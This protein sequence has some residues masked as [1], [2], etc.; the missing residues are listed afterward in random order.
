MEL[1]HIFF[2][3]KDTSA[4]ERL[5][6]SLGLTE[7]YR[8]KHPGQGTAN[9]CYCF[10]NAFLELLYVTDEAEVKT[11]CI[12]RTGL[13][14]RSEWRSLGTSPLGI[15]W[16][17]RPDEEEEGFETWSFNPP[18]MPSGIGIEV[19][20]DGDDFN[21]P[22]MFR[23]PGRT[24]TI[25]WPLDRRGNLQYAAG[26]KKISKVI[27]RHPNHF[28]PRDCLSHLANRLPIELRESE[29][30]TWNLSI[31]IETMDEQHRTLRVL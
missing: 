14:E 4:A 30:K 28:R 13:Y 1:D 19:S 7:T 23:S 11:S 18:Y 10:E 20:V 6:A 16:R 12:E 24:A 21:Q 8:R 22:M 26:M 15:S 9:I 29:G 25:E 3:V 5:A 27:V 31:V 2:F 17:L